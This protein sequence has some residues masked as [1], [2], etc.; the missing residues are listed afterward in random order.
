M[1]RVL[2]L[3]I[4]C[5]I[6]RKNTDRQLVRKKESTRGDYEAE[7]WVLFAIR[8]ENSILIHIFTVEFSIYFIAALCISTE[9]LSH[10]GNTFS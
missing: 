10:R 2:K 5:F 8:P 4:C 9:F 1:N 3:I 7:K 6:V